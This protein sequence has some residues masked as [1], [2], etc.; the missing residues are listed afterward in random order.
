MPPYIKSL[1]N[2]FSE[3]D[4]MFIIYKDGETQSI[5]H[6]R[7]RVPPLPKTKATA[8]RGVLYMPQ[9]SCLFSTT[10]FVLFLEGFRSQIVSM[11][12]LGP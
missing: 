8:K 9:Q 2:A 12:F 5:Q 4:M 7:Q 6:P 3:D 10:F 1:N 11:A